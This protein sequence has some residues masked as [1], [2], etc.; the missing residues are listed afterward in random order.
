MIGGIPEREKVILFWNALR[1]T[2]QQGLWHDRLHPEMSRF[3]EVVQRATIIEIAEEAVGHR[4][5]TG[6]SAPHDF[7]TEDIFDRRSR[8]DKRSGR[9]SEMGPSLTISESGLAATA[10]GERACGSTVIYA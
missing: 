9:Q 8:R 6:L 3:K 1:K 2:I 4:I 7:H 10:Y 5:H